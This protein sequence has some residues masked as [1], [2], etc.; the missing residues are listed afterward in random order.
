MASRG[1][2]KRGTEVEFRVCSAGNRDMFES[3]TKVAPQP[4]GN[5]WVS[6]ILAQL[7]RTAG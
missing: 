4:W 5:T 6:D 7:A 1:P 3:K 2:K